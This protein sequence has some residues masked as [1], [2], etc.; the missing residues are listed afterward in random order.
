MISS[1]K[2]YSLLLC[3]FLIAGVLSLSGFARVEEMQRITNGSWGGDHIQIEVDSNTATVEF[4]CAHG[5]IEGPFNVNAD[6]QFSWKGTF[7]REHGGPVRS[8]EGE[9]AIAAV[10][11]G[12]V[13]N[14]TMTLTIRLSNEKEPLDTFLLTQGK[15][16]RIRKC[17]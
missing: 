4:D 11:S 10:Y 12:S 17:R 7:S 13:K 5:T 15:P 8:D 16:G 9:T 1:T 6:G 14:Q 3:L 2:K